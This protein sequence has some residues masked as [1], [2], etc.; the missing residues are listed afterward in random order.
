MC[1]ACGNHNFKSKE[2]CNMCG[3]PKT[4]PTPSYGACKGGGCMRSAPYMAAMPSGMGGNM[5]PGDWM[6]PSCGNHNFSSRENCNR[7][8]NP[9]QM[10]KSMPQNLPP[11]FRDGDWMC[12]ECNNHNFASK[13]ACNKCGAPKGG[14]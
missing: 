13:T 5:R 12:P 4:A 8:G 2:K 14:A 3:G 10:P 1:A 11:N 6:C 7:C 9:K